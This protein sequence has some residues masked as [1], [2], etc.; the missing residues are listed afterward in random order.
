MERRKRAITQILFDILIYLKQKGEIMVADAIWQSI[1]NP[2]FLRVSETRETVEFVN[3]FPDNLRSENR[4]DLFLIRQIDSMTY[5][6]EWLINRVMRSGKIWVGT[7]VRSS[8]DH[9][10]V[11]V[12]DTIFDESYKKI[13][14]DLNCSMLEDA[15]E[16][17]DPDKPM[18]KGSLKDWKCLRSKFG[19]SALMSWIRQMSEQDLT[20]WAP[21]PRMPYPHEFGLSWAFCLQYAVFN[22]LLERKCSQHELLRNQCAVFDV[23]VTDED[24]APLVLT[25]FQLSLEGI[26]AA[27]FRGLS[28]SRLVEKIIGEG[29]SSRYES[30]R[31]MRPVKG[32][33]E[34]Q[35]FPGGRCQLV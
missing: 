22:I 26:P 11:E 25:P 28:V 21:Y 14:R 7:P 18:Q 16:M 33:W 29:D 10:Y 15:L 34:M 5:H 30:F 20:I 8:Q 3:Q 35:I 17:L 4:A 2:T 19:I 27:G 23:D 1:W 24:P 6:P 13:R 31:V 9:K 12:Q 32:M